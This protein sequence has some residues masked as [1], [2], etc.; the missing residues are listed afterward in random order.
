MADVPSFIDLNQLMDLLVNSPGLEVLILESCLP[1]Q[2]TQSPH[3]RIIHLP[4]L[5]HISVFG[6]SSCVT[7][8]LK[9]LKLPSSTELKMYCKSDPD[10][11]PI[12]NDHPLLPIFSAHYQSPAIEFKSLR[13]ALS[14]QSW[15]GIKASSFLPISRIRQPQIFGDDVDADSEFVLFLDELPGN[16]SWTDLFERLCNVLPISNLEFLSISA[17]DTDDSANWVGLFKRCTKVTRLQAV[18]CGTSSLVRALATPEH[19][20]TRPGGKTEKLRHD[21]RYSIP[22]PS[23]RSTALHAHGPIFPKLTSLSLKRLDFSEMERSSGTL[24]DVVQKALLQRMKTDSLKILRIG[25][26][27]IC[28]TRAKALQELVQ[29][30]YWD[31]EYG[32]PDEYDFVDYDD[33]PWPWWELSLDGTMY[34]E[35]EWREII[36]TGGG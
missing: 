22:A 3:G 13:V 5:S 10:D 2:L 12:Y 19:I 18:G 6:S 36:R 30:F 4:H 29:K 27:A 14:C 28:A 23:A 34:D 24:Y 17:P 32:L 26:S 7:N 16:G 21:N 8:L 35:Q 25:N 15:F 31:G 1:A 11:A 9:M 20:N 33:R